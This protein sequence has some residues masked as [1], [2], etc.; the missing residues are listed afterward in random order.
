M[1]AFNSLNGVPASADHHTLAGILRDE[2]GF[3]GF[4]VSDWNAVG[5][6][7]AH[8]VAL[9]G[10]EAAREKPS[11]PVWTWT[12]RAVFTPPNCRDWCAAGG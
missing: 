8:G 10:R 12:C 4:V 5:E 7:V 11:P 1:S 2:W 3:R 6:L 9:D